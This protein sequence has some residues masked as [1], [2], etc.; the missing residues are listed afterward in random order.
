MPLYA[1]VI[2]GF[3]FDEC[4]A[5]VDEF[6]RAAN[7]TVQ[8][9]GSVGNA[10]IEDGAITRCKL[11]ASNFFWVDV[12]GGPEN[13]VGELCEG[14]T[15]SQLESG[16]WAVWMVPVDNT[17]GATF[18]LGDR[19]SK[20]LLINGIKIGA[21]YLCKD[22]LVLCQYNATLDGWEIHNVNPPFSHFAGLAT[23]VT[24]GAPGPLPPAPGG[25]E[26][27]WTSFRGWDKLVNIINRLR[28][29]L[30][31][32]P[33]EPYTVPRVKADGN[34]FE[35]KRSTDVHPVYG[36]DIVLNNQ[37]GWDSGDPANSTFAL[38][39]VP[40]SSAIPEGVKTLYGRVTPD[41]AGQGIIIKD[42][43]TGAYNRLGVGE[44]EYLF[45]NLDENRNITY[46][47]N[48]ND[49]DFIIL[50]YII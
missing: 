46:V 13:Y 27:I 44:A 28:T 50:G 49:Y 10:D 19:P 8:I 39:N 6:N 26:R 29:G 16:M 23:K 48:G 2:Q 11:G 36:A 12:T 38:K 15:A 47:T 22:R 18:K 20:N 32:F 34:D 24:D 21:R 14:V 37:Q 25:S 5:G 9:L 30:F 1:V 31:R 40:V 45:V 42:P 43:D 41:G 33:A 17:A 4:A 3:K 7:P 35:Y